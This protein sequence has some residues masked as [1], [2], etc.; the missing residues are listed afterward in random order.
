MP[1]QRNPTS[2]GW[3]RYPC[4]PQATPQSAFSAVPFL[5]KRLEYYSFHQQISAPRTWAFQQIRIPHVPV[6]WCRQTMD[7]HHL[8]LHHILQMR[9]TA[10]PSHPQPSR[11]HRFG[12]QHGF[13]FQKQPVHSRLYRSKSRSQRRTR[14]HEF[15]AHSRLWWWIILDT[16][17]HSTLP[18]P[19]HRHHPNG[20]VKNISPANLQ[21]LQSNPHRCSG[22]AAGYMLLHWLQSAPDVLP[23]TGLRFPYLQRWAYRWSQRLLP[24]LPWFPGSWTALIYGQK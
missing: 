6:R 1:F 17:Q 14:L 7:Y 19:Q 24:M 2:A 11:K 3:Y 12:C 16:C 13:R 4:H 8:Y 21:N 9:H 5:C 18:I 15:S 23:H 22:D 10:N 20:D